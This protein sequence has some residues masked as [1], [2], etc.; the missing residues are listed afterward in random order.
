M[1]TSTMRP[2]AALSAA[3]NDEELTIPEEDRQVGII[4]TLRH[5]FAHNR[6]VNALMVIAIVVGFFQGWMKL[7]L[8]G[9]W[10]TFAFDIPVMLALLLTI[11]SV[12]RGRN[13]FPDCN[14]GKVLMLL[15]GVGVLYVL[16]PFGVPLL[17]AIAS[18]RAWCLIPLIFLVGYHSTRSVRQMEVYLWLLTILGVVVSIYAAFF[19]TV[20]EVQEMMKSDPELMYRLQNSFY[21]DSAGHGVF[22]R[23]S[24]FVSS[25]AFGGMMAYCTTF[26]VARLSHPGC[27]LMERIWLL[28]SSVVMG[29]GVVISGSRSSLISVFMGV[30]FAA[31]Y[32][33]GTWVILA[34]PIFGLGSLFLGYLTIGSSA[35]ERFGTLLDLD[36]VFQRANIVIEPAIN[37]L[38]EYPLGDGLGR[39][40]HGV[41]LILYQLTREIEI[42][43]IDG[44]LGRMVVDM[45]IV[46]LVIFGALVVVGITDSF[47]WM[48][49]LRGSPL[50][51]VGL[52]AGSMFILAASQL[53]Y[54]SPFLGIPGGVLL[55]FFLG[56]MRRLVEDYDKLVAVVGQEVADVAPQF[57]SFI[58]PNR[59]MPL[60]KQDQ[61]DRS[62]G[63]RV[64]GLTTKTL[65]PGIG[66][67]A[68]AAQ[69]PAVGSASPGRIRSLTAPNKPL[70]SAMGTSKTS[71][72]QS[73]GNLPVTKRFLFRRP[74]DSPDR[75]RPRR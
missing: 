51:V 56:S 35:F 59:L 55:W 8:R 42:R 19:Q 37:S 5:F 73:G 25:A 54:G 71:P 72:L 75:R 22:R 32:R 23:F 67:G 57:V 18:F 12:R 7:H 74:A 40:G 60:F 47:Q 66:A 45:G 52:P 1:Q 13:L 4:S 29:Y 30:A 49:K 65:N 46:G 53:L 6:A 3:D 24:T 69:H 16:L 70:G 58:T 50:G 33:R 27:S 11:T 21:A 17:I 26:A 43:T 15:T 48:I 10:V 14:M 64:R 28:T 61:R 20:E 31:W 38:M 2:R 68:T 63:S 41:P 9:S 34:A 44:D 39:S 62:Q 36:I